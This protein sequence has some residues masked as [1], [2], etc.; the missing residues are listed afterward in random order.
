MMK[1]DMKKPALCLIALVFLLVLMAATE[2]LHVKTVYAGFSYYIPKQQDQLA[3]KEDGSVELVRYFEFAVNTSS[4]DSGTEIWVGLPTS[5]TRVS[6]VKDQEGKDVK[7]QTRSSQGEY[8]LILSGFEA[9]KPGT[10]R[11]FTVTATIPDFLFPD[12]R[13]Q[14]YVT[15]QYIPGW[16]SSE[17]KVQDIAVILPGKVEKSE[18]KTGSRLWD[19]IAQKESGAY[20]VTWQFR[21]LRANEKVSINIGFPDKYV[22]LAPIEKPQPSPEPSLPPG[23]PR[24]SVPGVGG[25]SG[26]IV[27]AAF[28]PILIVMVSLFAIAG[29]EQ[30]SSPQ[31]RM[32]GIGVNTD[33]TPIEASVLLR[34]PP[35]KTL[36]LM[37]FSL[38]KKGI[39]RVYS[40]EP[41]KLAVEYE[42]DLSEPERLFVEAIDRAKG[43]IDPKKLVPVFRYLVASVNEKMKPYCRKDTEEFYRKK[44]ASLWKEIRALETPE[45]RLSAMD[46]NIFW[47][48]Q[49]EA[50]AKDSAAQFEEACSDV[51]KSSLPSKPTPDYSGP[52]SWFRGFLMGRYIL[53]Q[54][55]PYGYPGFPFYML[56]PSIYRNYT[57]IS[58]DI[59][60]GEGQRFREITESIF[61]PVAPHSSTG[62]SGFRGGFTPPSCACACACVSCA[63]ACACAGGGGCT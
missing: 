54:P 45:L 52:F 16:W 5:R 38:I 57:G 34:Q 61:A 33:L 13:N 10:S 23:F 22:K 60:G 40:S 12:N 17:V 42:R 56:Y 46:E 27:L 26:L 47:L 4:S 3:I 19:G 35:E 37:L 24:P 32:E 41:L 44:I 14:G 28:I 53:G 8:L 20:V 59:L 43:E 21:D 50:E 25:N 7:F 30:Y 2:L 15:M 55:F 31:V 9:I 48:L 51:D 36:T 1:S 62:R 58:R 6:S 18:I 63:C 39:L 49:D 29:K 11:A